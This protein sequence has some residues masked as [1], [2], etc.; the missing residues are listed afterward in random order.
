MV[1]VDF[2]VYVLSKH[3]QNPLRITKDNNSNRIGPYLLI[4][5]PNIYLVDIKV[6]AK[7]DEIPSLPVQQK[8]KRRGRTN[9]WMDN[10][11]TV[12]TPTNTVCQGV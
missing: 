8:S 5:F 2:P 11:K 9:G 3:K 10:V 6:F 12:H 4:F 1:Q 7:F